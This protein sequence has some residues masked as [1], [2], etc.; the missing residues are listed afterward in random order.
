[1]DLRSIFTIMRIKVLTTA[2]AIFASLGLLAISAAGQVD[3]VKEKLNRT[4]A[5]RK[6]D[7]H[8]LRAIQSQRAGTFDPNADSL[9]AFDD[10]GRVKVSIRVNVTSSLLA[11]IRKEG[12]KVIS[13][14]TRYKD[15]QA[16]IP[17]GSLESIASNRTVISIN[18]S[19][20]GTTNNPD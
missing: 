12:G 5:Q 15:I 7:S 4:P 14:S 11:R 20:R 17:L 9:L 8:L 19:E 6:I 16:F 2:I 1:L 10:K 13:S 3:P 18:P